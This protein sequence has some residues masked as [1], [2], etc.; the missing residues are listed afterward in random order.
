MSLLAIDMGSS[1]CKAMAIAVDG[2]ILAEHSYSY[3][4]EIP[5][6]S[7]AQM[8]AGEFCK[9]LAC[10]TRKLSD[11]AS[12]DPV[13]VLAISSHAETFVPVDFRLQPVGPAILN[14]DKRAVE[15]ATWVA[16][17]LG[18]NRIFEITGLTAH[19]MYPVPK[20][21][22]MRENQPDIFKS[23]A[24]F[25][26]VVDYLLTHLGLPP[27]IDFSHASRFLAFDIR[28]KRWSADILD[29]CELTADRFATPVPAGTLAGSL[30]SQVANDLGLR[31]GTPVVVGGHDQ[32]CSAL[33]LGVL[34]PGR[35]SA[36]LGTYECLLSTA[37]TPPLNDTAFHANL[38]ISC[39]VVPNRYAT[40]AYFPSGIMLEWFLQLLHEGRA[41]TTSVGDICTAL[42]ARVPDGPTGL[43]VVPHLLGTC[44]PDFNPQATGV[45]V[46]LRPEM[47]AAHIYK[48][49]LEGVACE[50]SAMTELLQRVTGSFQDLFVSGGGCRS[51]L[52]LQLRAALTGC[53]LH[54]MRCPEAV[55]LGTAILAG[56]GAGKYS[57]FPEAIAQL[58]QVADTIHPDRKMADDYHRQ[59]QQYRQVY[60]SLAGVREPQATKIS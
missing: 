27:C 36:S 4:P 39:H 46:G 25:L 40:I 21:L 60:S 47:R 3:S 10:V 13:E 17:T 32:P 45:M 51:Q 12:Q 48:G 43:L 54:Q 35:V 7:W 49:I 6:P 59:L 1:S 30:T 37:E 23:A 50:L 9:A 34:D 31:P 19:P 57:G 24:K 15:Q 5:H 53:R 2:R 58:V 41:D 56:V 16:E 29:A 28:K 26:S 55:C 52:G 33:G 42:E 14:T 18:P 44:N 38:N 8:P 11:L 22:W 20:I